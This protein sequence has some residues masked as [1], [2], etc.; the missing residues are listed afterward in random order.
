MDSWVDGLEDEYVDGGWMERDFSLAPL[1]KL[2]FSHSWL[3]LNLT[4]A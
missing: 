3:F 2:A 4:W 1:L